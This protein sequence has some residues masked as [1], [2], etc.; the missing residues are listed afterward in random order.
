[1]PKDCW[2]G[3]L[4]KELYEL[5]DKWTDDKRSGINAA[6]VMNVVLHTMAESI[7]LEA[8]SPTV[9]TG[10]W[11]SAMNH[12]NSGVLIQECKE[13]GVDPADYGLVDQGSY[14][15]KEEPSKESN[16]D[17]VVPFEPKGVT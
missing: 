15:N 14:D 11:L 17:N 3:E 16:G 8:P 1:M 5:L 2:H 9:A 13:N 10:L 4:V 12:G 7:Y 6:E